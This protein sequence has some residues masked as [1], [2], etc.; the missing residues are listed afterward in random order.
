[1]KK[2][3]LLLILVSTSIFGQNYD[4]NWLKVIEFENEGKIKSA[5]EI[6]SKIRQKATR[7]KDEVQIIKCFFYESKYLQVLDEDA[8]TK[9]INNL[10]TEINKV[11][12]PSKAILNLVYAKCLIDYRNQN[13]YL[14][15]N[16][17]NTVSFDDQF[18]T[19]T[20]KDF[21][22]QIDGALKKTLLNETILKQTSLST[23]LQIFDYS[24][25]EKTKKDNLFNYLVKENIALYTP[26]IR[27]WEIQ[28]KEFLPYEKGFLENSESFAQLNFDFVK[29]EKLKKVLELYQKQEKNTPTL[30]NQFDRIQFCNNVLLDSNEGFMKSLRSM[31]KESKDTILIQKIQLEKAIILNNLAS[32]EAHPDYNIQAIATL[33]SILKINNRSNA[34]KI[35]LQK[36]QNI[37]AKSLNIQLQKFSYTDEN[38]RAF[39]RYKNLNRLSV[40]FFKIDQNM[41]KNFRN[42]PHNKDSLVAAIIKNKKAIASKNYVLEEKNNYFEYST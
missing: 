29:N 39:I 36:I 11:S 2:I 40:S 34:H 24:D 19:W 22:E 14:L 42:S 13:S 38:T 6:V 18:L 31:Q 15:Y 26:Q 8:Q 32:K 4:K 3:F 5:N 1:M 30:E 27:Q 23:Y 17:T 12:I 10:K 7:D 16:R 20:P 9:I 21:S 41:T 37:Q 28:K 33:D 35:A 25:E